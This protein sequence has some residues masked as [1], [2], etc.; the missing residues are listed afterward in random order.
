M[1]ATITSTGTFSGLDNLNP[2]SQGPGAS[3]NEVLRDNRDS[4]EQRF[5]PRALDYPG[6]FASDVDGMQETMQ[7]V[8]IFAAAYSVS[9]HAAATR[10]RDILKAFLGHGSQEFPQGRVFTP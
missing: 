4:T 7:F 6:S 8:G 2:T 9:P 10:I 5:Q 1:P 3:V